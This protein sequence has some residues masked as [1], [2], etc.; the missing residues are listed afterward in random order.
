VTSKAAELDQVYALYNG[1]T[2]VLQEAA[3]GR[4]PVR[5][6]GPLHAPV[7]LVGEAPGAVEEKEGAPFLGPSG[8]LL[9]HLFARAGVPWEFCYRTN[10]L[11][12]RP[13]GNRTPYP[14]EVTA[15]RPRLVQEITIISPLIV[16]A[17]GGTAWRGLTAGRQGSF[18]DNRGAWLK[19]QAP[20]LTCDL[21]SIWH[22][23]AIL[24]A[25]G[26]QR[27]QMETETVTALRSV[28]EG[29]RA[30]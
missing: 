2:A 6:A 23:G 9:R 18:T 27:E 17:A 16:I 24:R 28:T 26:D 10:V 4:P 22:P 25:Y 29:D 14:Y 7:V 30:S 1:G 3:A 13:P 20:E 12:W 11:P 5:G 19:W 15:L 8:Q 21:I